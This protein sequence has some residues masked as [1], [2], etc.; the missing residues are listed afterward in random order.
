[1][2]EGIIKFLVQ[3]R[4]RH[5]YLNSCG[6]LH[7]PIEICFIEG[8]KRSFALIFN[9]SKILGLQFKIQF[10]PEYSHVGNN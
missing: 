6:I 7:I 5:I 9:H 2:S 8:I 10:P 4:L 3:T 1:M